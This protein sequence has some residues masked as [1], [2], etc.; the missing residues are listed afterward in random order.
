MRQCYI[1]T[2]RACSRL[3]LLRRF[4]Y[5]P[6]QFKI[7]ILKL[8]FAIRLLFIYIFYGSIHIWLYT[9]TVDLNGDIEKN[10]GPT[11]SSSEKFSICHGNLNSI[12][13]HSYVKVSLLKGYF[14]IHKFNIVCLLEIYFYPSVPLH[15]ANLDIQGYEI[16]LI[17]PPFTT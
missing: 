14:L 16:S 3:V 15:D 8:V 5:P 1:T 17:R 9:R 2:F 13:A 11:L 10:P 12:T 7:Q 6:R 4:I